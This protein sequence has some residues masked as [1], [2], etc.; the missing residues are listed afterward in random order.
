MTSPMYHNDTWDLFIISSAIFFYFLA[1]E[2]IHNIYYYATK[3]RNGKHPHAIPCCNN[4]CK[5][6]NDASQRI[7]CN[8]DYSR[9]SHHSKCHIRY[10]VKERLYKATLKRFSKNCNRK[11]SDNSA[12]NT[13]N[14]YVN[15]YISHRPLPPD[16]G[17]I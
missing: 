7:R 1:Q 3:Y 12:H 6:C 2:R 11:H 15:V 17:I 9:K 8:L 14:K 13:S 4:S 16:E 5:Q 10:I